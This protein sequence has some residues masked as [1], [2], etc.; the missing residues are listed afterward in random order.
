MKATHPSPTLPSRGNLCWKIAQIENVHA[1]TCGC[2]PC[3]KNKVLQP[4]LPWL[5][6]RESKLE[7]ESKSGHMRM[8]KQASSPSSP[9]Q[10]RRQ[11]MAKT[12][13]KP[14]AKK[15]LGQRPREVLEMQHAVWC[16]TKS[17]KGIFLPS[18]G[19]SPWCRERRNRAKKTTTTS[20]SST[21]TTTVTAT[22]TATATTTVWSFAWGRL[23]GLMFTTF[24]NSW[25][26]EPNFLAAQ[27]GGVSSSRSGR[28]SS[29]WRYV[30]AAPGGRKVALPTMPWSY[31]RRT[32]WSFGML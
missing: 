31:L 14:S 1:Y 27:L 10:R 23:M 25:P 12:A 5:E 30:G 3:G 15:Q 18:N 4:P 9:N 20:S 28:V 13:A 11:L 16:L 17:L 2:R 32:W 6:K 21:T 22:A 8:K 29:R 19:F 24:C 26:C 7:Q